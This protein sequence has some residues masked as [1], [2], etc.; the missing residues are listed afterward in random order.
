MSLSS[1]MSCPSE[2]KRLACK[3]KLLFSSKCQASV[4]MAKWPRP[5][6]AFG[7]QECDIMADAKNI[8]PACK[9]RKLLK[10]GKTLLKPPSHLPKGRMNCKS[11]PERD[12]TLGLVCEAWSKRSTRRGSGI[13][14]FHRAFSTFKMPH[15]THKQLRVPL[16]ALLPSQAPARPLRLHFKLQDVPGRA[17][18]Q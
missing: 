2:T 17:R 12:F 11:T 1:Q 15:G 3:M 16:L 5:R 18:V 14:S 10:R 7:E 4:Q 13:S 9:L 8:T 6:T